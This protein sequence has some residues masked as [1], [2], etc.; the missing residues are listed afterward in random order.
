MNTLTPPL[1][2][3]L[4]PTPLPQKGRG[5]KALYAGILGTAE[6]LPSPFW[7]EGR[8]EGLSEGVRSAG[9]RTPSASPADRTSTEVRGLHRSSWRM[10]LRDASNILTVVVSSHP[11]GSKPGRVSLLPGPF[12]Y[13]CARCV[14]PGCHP[15]AGDTTGADGQS[16]HDDNGRVTPW[17]MFRIQEYSIQR[18]ITLSL[19][20]R[21]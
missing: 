4:R 1:A 14:P 6:E 21:G 15:R 12:C 10:V 11:L 16:V 17:G 13:P 8:S 20:G 18:R 5:E 2:R 9:L 19:L 7:G 3:D